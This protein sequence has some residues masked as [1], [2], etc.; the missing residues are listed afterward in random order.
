MAE[1]TPTPWALD[2]S[3][4]VGDGGLTIADCGKS[5]S[6]LRKERLANAAFIVKAC[7][8]HE[9]LVKALQPFAAIA[10]AVFKK[11]E[12]APGQFREPYSD[13]PDDRHFY[14][15]NNVSL[16]YGDLRAARRALALLAADAGDVS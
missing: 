6:Y 10:E 2:G 14:G 9:A 4:V 12:T 11:Y 7:N 1:Y 15:F 3:W 13:E 8:S 5:S 16:T